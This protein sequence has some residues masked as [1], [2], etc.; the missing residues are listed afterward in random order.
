MK[1]NINYLLLLIPLLVA[2]SFAATA[3]NTMKPNVTLNG[4]CEI[5]AANINVGVISYNTP[6][7]HN[8]L[9]IKCS[10]GTNYR[11]YMPLDSDTPYGS[12]RYLRSGD[13]LNQDKVGYQLYFPRGADFNNEDSNAYEYFSRV[14]SPANGQ[15]QMIPLNIYFPK[16]NI[17]P[18]EGVYTSNLSISIIY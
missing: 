15:T 8:N 12:T 6:T 3:T 14:N 4:T 1:N 18:R 5:S 9:S 13:M 17:L 16:P 2:N 7:V 10:K 11:L